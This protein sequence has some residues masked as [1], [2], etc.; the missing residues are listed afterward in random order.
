VHELIASFESR[1]SCRCIR[2]LLSCSRP[3]LLSGVSHTLRTAASL[4]HV[5]PIHG[6]QRYGVASGLDACSHCYYCSASQGQRHQRQCRRYRS[7]IK[8]AS[9]TIGRQCGWF[10][11]SGKQC[12]LTDDSSLIVTRAP[13]RS[14]AP[15]PRTIITEADKWEQKRR[16]K[17]VRQASRKKKSTMRKAAEG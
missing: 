1:L 10:R 11:V 8:R 7:G 2:C 14:P 6:P 16:K 5:R 4:A 12:S 13:S 15:R 9:K 3:W 17:D